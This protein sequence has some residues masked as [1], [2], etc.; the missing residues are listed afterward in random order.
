MNYDEAVGYIHA[1]GRFGSKLGLER[2]QEA[3]ARLGHP[4]R[5]YKV[6][7]VAGTNGKGSTSAMLA[8]VLRAAGYKTGLYTSPYL[9][10]FT[11]RFGLDGADI[12][13]EALARM[14]TQLKPLADELGLTQFEFI[15][16]LALLYYA[17]SQVDI[18]VLEVGLGGRF[19]ATNVVV[20]EMSI[21]TNIGFDHMEVLGDTLPKIAFEKA[22]IIKPGIPVVTATMDESSLS[23]IAEVAG[24]NAAPLRILNKDFSATSLTS[25]LCGQTFFYQNEKV[26]L[27][28]NLSLLGLHQ[29]QNASLAVDA[30]LWLRELGYALTI[31][32]IQRG[33]NAVRWPGRF[34][35]VAEHP[36]L[37]MDG[38]HNTHGVVALVKSLA[39]LLPGRKVLL[40]VGIM[41]DKEPREMLSLLAPHVKR[42]YASAP[43]L[44]RATPAG[45]LATLA[46]NL[47]LAGEHYAS[48]ALALIAALKDATPLDLVLV[49]GSLYTVSEARSACSA[50]LVN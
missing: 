23:V 43:K 18:V 47:G 10:A 12:G 31:L 50:P 35:V 25:S 32:D 17:Q 9:D 39:E 15:T 8:S 4:E 19:D 24:A 21:I 34:E 27:E 28:F 42:F 49:A 48:V 20:P 16:A 37:I 26:A 6:L 30:L 13:Q 41:Q 5:Q 2:M 14:V 40:V 38:A 29:V 33:L 1:L 45:E 22:G 7:H 46:T 11:D 44:P 36:L 3:L